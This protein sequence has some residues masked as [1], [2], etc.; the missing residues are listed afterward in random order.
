MISL[1]VHLNWSS[2][3][4]FYN[5]IKICPTWNAQVQNLPTT[6]VFLFELTST[7]RHGWIYRTF[8]SISLSQAVISTESKSVPLRSGAQAR[9]LLRAS[10]FPIRICL[11]TR[12]WTVSS[13]NQPNFVLAKVSTTTEAKSVSFTL[14]LGTGSKPTDDLFVLYWNTAA[15]KI[16]SWFPQRSIST[17]L[18]CMLTRQNQNLSSLLTMRFSCFLMVHSWTVPRRS[19]SSGVS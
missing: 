4:R 3:G 9:N 12:S 6:S 11:K 13:A 7:F 2:P 10:G 8:L 5:R 14:P 18:S 15:L 1:E 19:I 16:Y 17:G